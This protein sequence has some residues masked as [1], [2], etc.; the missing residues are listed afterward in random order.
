MTLSARDVS[1]KAIALNSGLHEVQILFINFQPNLE[2][3]SSDS[4][5]FS[6][7]FSSD[8]LTSL[9]FTV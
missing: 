9:I 8:Q 6:G 2:A 4:H 1:F 5:T 3:F 7:F